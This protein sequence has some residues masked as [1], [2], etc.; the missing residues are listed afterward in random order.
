L[1]FAKL[2]FRNVSVDATPTS[3]R[4]RPNA[5]RQ[6]GEEEGFFEY[7]FDEGKEARG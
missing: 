7:A 5:S 6:G 1:L 3:P 2:S 4:D